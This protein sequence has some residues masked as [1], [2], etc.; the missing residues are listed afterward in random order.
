MGMKIRLNNNEYEIHDGQ[1]IHEF[2]EH[3]NLHQLKGTAV[4]V[5]GTVIPKSFWER[6]S[7]KE[8]DSILMITASQ[9]G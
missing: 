4:A 2:L 7:L 3:N 8:N 5:N 1:T 6:T 9:G